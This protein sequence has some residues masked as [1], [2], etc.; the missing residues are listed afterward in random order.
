MSMLRTYQ[1]GWTPLRPDGDVTAADTILDASTAGSTL[2]WE[3]RPTAKW[4][5]VP[6]GA[7]GLAVR[8]EMYDTSDG[9][10]ARADFFGY[11]SNGP[12]MF[13]GDMSLAAGT[14][15]ISDLTTDLHI[16]TINEDVDAQIGGIAVYDSG[17]DRIAQINFD[18]VGYSHI[19]C[20]LTEFTAGTSLM[21]WVCWY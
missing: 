1:G 10:T 12:A 6:M 17:T 4:W 18:N 19:V 21:P 7:N 9:K 16:D 13:L 11:R 5:E 8:F 2:D 3:D 20:L 15:R 14:A